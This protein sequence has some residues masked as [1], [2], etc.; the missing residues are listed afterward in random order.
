M[1]S[2]KSVTTATGWTKSAIDDMESI[3]RGGFKRARA[4]LGVTGFGISVSDLPPGFDRTP[5]H[6]HTFDGQEEVYI[7]L[8]GSGWLDFSTAENG[9]ERV[10]IDPN[11]VVRVGPGTHRSVV[12]GPEGIRVMIAGGTPGKPYEPF[13]PFE[14]GAPEPSLAELPG[15]REA[16]GEP[17]DNDW[18]ASR[19]DAMDALNAAEGVKIFP[20]RRALGMSAF[21]I[22]AFDLEYAAAYPR[23]DHTDSG[24]E[25]VYVVTVGEGTL[26]LDG[27]RVPV[28]RHDMIRVGPEVQRHWAPGEGGIS[29]IAIGAPPGAVYEPPGS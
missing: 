2:T 8:E 16:Q 11:N 28:E 27:N 19:Y 20:I 23:H 3:W 6:V 21:G 29:F 24:Q 17:G 4:A 15:I 14:V 26:E 7:A 9:N 10:A 1:T 25:E 18:S 12:A 22:N 13:A 5:P